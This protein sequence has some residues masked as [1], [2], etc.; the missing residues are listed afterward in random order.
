MKSTL[1]ALPAPFAAD[2]RFD[3]SRGQVALNDNDFP[4]AV[5][6]LDSYLT[7]YP[8][9]RKALFRLERALRLGGLIARADEVAR[10]GRDIDDAR[11][12]QAE[13]YA[14]IA[15]LEPRSIAADPDL[16]R[17]LASL[18]ERLGHPAEAAA[19]TAIAEGGRESRGDESKP[20][21]SGAGK[22]PGR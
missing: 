1:A 16:C 4:A 17:L 21:L 22:T 14:R 19:W 5:A 7:I 8:A 6:A 20:P 10:R 3:G 12:E 18:R 11:A 13:S 15:N 2:P 9:D